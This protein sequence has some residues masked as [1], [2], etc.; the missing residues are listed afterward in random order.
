MEVG[1]PVLSEDPELA[2]ASD[3]SC[4]GTSA[5][6]EETLTIYHSIWVP[7]IKL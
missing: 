6:C 4:E 1:K 2:K 3:D 5:E 7:S